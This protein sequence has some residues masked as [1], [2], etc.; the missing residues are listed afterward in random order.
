MFLCGE[1]GHNCERKCLSINQNV[2]V[3]GLREGCMF[4]VNG[5]NTYM[6]GIHSLRLFKYGS[7][8]RE[9]PAGEDLSFLLKV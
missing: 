9:I 5:A 6:K 4:F 2:H 3:A 7:E 8:P 1:F